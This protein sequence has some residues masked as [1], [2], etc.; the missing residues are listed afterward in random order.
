MKDIQKQER[1]E[2]KGILAREELLG[3]FTTR[4]LCGWTDKR[5]N[6]EYRGRLEKNWRQWKGR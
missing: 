3:R 6:K 1:E 4:K 5:Y 2:N